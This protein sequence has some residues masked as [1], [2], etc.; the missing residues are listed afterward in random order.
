MLSAVGG[1]LWSTHTG[2]LPSA[3]VVHAACRR[4]YV[5]RPPVDRERYGAFS[6]T[7]GI[8]LAAPS[9]AWKATAGPCDA[10]ARDVPLCIIGHHAACDRKAWGGAFVGLPQP[11]KK[12]QQDEGAAKQKLKCTQRKRLGA[13]TSAGRAAPACRYEC[14][15]SGIPLGQVHAISGIP[16]PAALRRHATMSARACARML[17]DTR[18]GK[19]LRCMRMPSRRWC[20]RGTRGPPAADVG[21]RGAT[22]VATARSRVRAPSQPTR[23]PIRCN[24]ASRV[25]TALSRFVRR[26]NQRGCQSV[27]TAHRGLQQR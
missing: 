6:R 2:V 14:A 10:C 7:C 12:K 25:A 17:E 11:A 15:M 9:A 26:R 1:V 27:A 20:I 19:E 18:S 22:R 21:R 24:G 23:L 16:L 8:R 4:R 3:G 5:A 13:R